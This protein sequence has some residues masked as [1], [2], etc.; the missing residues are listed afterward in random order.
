MIIQTVVPADDFAKS[1]VKTLYVPP[2]GTN[3]SNTFNTN[4][5]AKGGTNANTVINAVGNPVQ[6]WPV[7]ANTRVFKNGVAQS[8]SKVPP[9][10]ADGAKPTSRIWFCQ[11][12]SQ[13]YDYLLSVGRL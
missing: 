8:S 5:D 7:P 9:K 1:L 10:A 13:R 2:S 4:A 3:Y 12:V 11:S 6:Q